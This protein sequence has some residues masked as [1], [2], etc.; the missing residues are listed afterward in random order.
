MEDRVN[1]RMEHEMHAWILRQ[2]QQRSMQLALPQAPILDLQMTRDEIVRR[3]LLEIEGHS[4]LFGS[5]S[6]PESIL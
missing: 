1:W 3:L 6:T 2:E 5:S 4:G